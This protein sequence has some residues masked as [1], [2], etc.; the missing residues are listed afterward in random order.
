MGTAGKQEDTDLMTE[1][2]RRMGISLLK[3]S[4]KTDNPLL[5]DVEEESDYLKGVCACIL[6]R[7][8]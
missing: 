7:A 1:I 4:V 3:N 5:I 2:L 8:T 6:D